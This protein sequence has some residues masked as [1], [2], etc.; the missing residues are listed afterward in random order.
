MMRERNIRRFSLAHLLENDS[1]DD[2]SAAAGSVR[3]IPTSLGP[4]D[5]TLEA[6][7]D[8]SADRTASCHAACKVHLVEGS[9]SEISGEQQELLRSRLRSASLLTFVAF[10]I[11]LVWHI[12]QLDLSVARPL[13]LPTFIWH[14]IAT[15][16]VGCIGFALCS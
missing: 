14:I 7:S 10:A 15:L 3:H 12:F 1:L 9:G 11:F 6:P 4:A 8:P 16:V 13:A 2:S 5:I